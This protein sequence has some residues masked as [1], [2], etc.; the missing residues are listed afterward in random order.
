MRRAGIHVLLVV[1]SI[2]PAFGCGPIVDLTKGLQVEIVSSGWFDAGIFDRKNKLFPSVS[3]KLKNVS[4]Q[5]LPVLQINALFHRVGE[6]DEWGSGFLTAVGSE[7]LA[8]GAETAVLTIRSQLGYTGTESRDE[9]FKNSRFVDATV[10]L[11][12]KY[13]STQWTRLGQY[14]IARQ[15]ILR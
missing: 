13:G 10:D 15:L 14:P 6:T 11:L 2:L 7:G 9:M 8:P 12:G 1:L 3:F 4:T 5:K